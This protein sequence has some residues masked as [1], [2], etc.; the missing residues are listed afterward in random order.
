M[1]AGPRGSASFIVCDKR[2]DINR[3]AL[4]YGTCG[5]QWKC[6]AEAIARWVVG[7]LGLRRSGRRSGR[8]GSLH[9]GVAA[10]DTRRQ[11]LCLRMH[12]DVALVAADKAVPL[13]DLVDFGHGAYAL[14]TGAIRQLV[15]S[16]TTPD[17]RYTP[18][19][20]RREARKL[21][22]QARHERW[23]TAHR[24][25]RKRRP[26]MSKGWYAQQIAKHEIAEGRSV[27][28]IRKHLTT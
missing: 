22:T 3:V 7:H 12:G 8:S 19:T 17:P 10:G 5:N 4:T 1:P 21:D 6:D 2:S 11:M 28:T 18:S 9:L 16:A 26:N 15:D 24:D 23:R 27:A 20:A 25:L 13:A 14:D